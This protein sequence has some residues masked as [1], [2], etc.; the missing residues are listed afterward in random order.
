MLEQAATYMDQSASG[1][2]DRARRR[3]ELLRL[4]FQEGLPIKQIAIL[5]SVA[6]NRLHEEYRVA[7]R[8]FFTSLVAVV[9]MHESEIANGDHCVSELAQ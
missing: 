4:R 3:V 9:A 6:A 2:G 7:R 5:W 1:K 8:E